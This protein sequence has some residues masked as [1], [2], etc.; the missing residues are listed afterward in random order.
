MKTSHL[1]SY[2]RA[3]LES[4]LR[5]MR[6]YK[7]YTLQAG[8]R[9]KLVDSK[10]PPILFIRVEYPL[11]FEQKKLES[12]VKGAL[13]EYFPETKEKEYSLEYKQSSY[14]VGGVRIFC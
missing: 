6:T 11:S 3:D 4:L 13:P 2:S 9:A 7:S 10:S 12:F 14:I 5:V 8:D 1:T